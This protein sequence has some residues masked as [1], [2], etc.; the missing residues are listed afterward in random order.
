M[1][2]RI[3]L[4]L[5]EAYYMGEDHTSSVP[6]KAFVSES[7]AIAFAAEEAK[8][9]LLGETVSV[10]TREDHPEFHV[11]EFYM[12]DSKGYFMGTIKVEPL[13]LC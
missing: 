10:I 2:K 7:D 6:V 3:Y 11:T 9:D 8:K 5:R 1:E 13:D 12:E 4:V